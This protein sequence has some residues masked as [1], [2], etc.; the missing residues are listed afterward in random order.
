[1]N[2]LK[3]KSLISILSTC[4]FAFVLAPQPGQAEQTV[5]QSYKSKVLELSKKIALLDKASQQLR[6]AYSKTVKTYQHKHKALSK[7]IYTIAKNHKAKRTW[8]NIK[9]V[10]QLAKEL[11]ISGERF[12]LKAKAQL[13]KLFHIERNRTQWLHRRADLTVAWSIVFLSRRIQKYEKEL[14]RV[15]DAVI[16][17]QIGHLRLQRDKLMRKRINIEDIFKRNMNLLGQREASA[18]KHFSPDQ[19]E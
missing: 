8:A 19:P 4:L 9:K 12:E 13:R 3:K 15:E 1:M 10:K 7:A 5:A 2:R 11:K 6:K 16:A 17:T 18:L 14:K